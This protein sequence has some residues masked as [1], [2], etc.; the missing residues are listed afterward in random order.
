MGMEDEL[1]PHPRSIFENGGLEEE[2]R[3]AYVGITRA[4]KKLYLTH[5]HKR[6]LHGQTTYNIPSRFVG[7]IPDRLIT[8]TKSRTFEREMSER[9]SKRHSN[10]SRLGG[11]KAW[12]SRDSYETPTQSNADQIGLRVGDSVHHDMFGNG[13]IVELEVTEYEAIATINFADEGQKTLDLSWAPGTK[14]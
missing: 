1:F 11:T 14:I 12:S 8:H 13:V 2:H 10:E 6:T 9:V 3:L 7:Y 4:E 5:A